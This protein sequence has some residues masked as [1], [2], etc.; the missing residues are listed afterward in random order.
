MLPP[1]TENLTIPGGIKLF[2]DAGAGERDLGNIVD[3][4]LDPKT[5]ELKHYTNRSGKRRVDKVFPIEEELTMKFKLDE[6]VAENLA[7]YFKGGPAELVGAGS[8]QVTDQKVT[9][10]GLILSS[11]GKYGLSAMTVRQFLDKCFRY[12]G[13]AFVDHSEEGDTEAGTPFD[14]LQDADDVLYLGKNTLFKEVYA[15]LAV[16]GAYTGIAWEYWDGSAWQALAVSGAGANLD[17][18]GPITF[19]PPGDWAKTTVNGYTGYFIRAKAT[20][21]TTAATVNCFRQNLVQNA[22]YILD[23]GRAGVDGRLVGRAGRL[24]SG[25]I[26]DGEEVMASFTYTTWTALRFPIAAGNFVEGAAR[27]ECHPAEGRG[28]RF[29]IEIPRCQLK[30]NGALTLDDKKTL[31]VPMTLEVLDNYSATP[32]YPYGRVVML[33]EV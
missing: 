22:D 5:E 18:D 27:L 1:S 2:F 16:N 33:N 15:D 31:E 23:P 6:P 21:V 8:A 13:A 12:D 30:P 26:A 14:A 32:D 24:A 4:D 28:L 17:A 29:D 3:L 19:M 11:L 25:K 7:A 9:L 20:A 10:N